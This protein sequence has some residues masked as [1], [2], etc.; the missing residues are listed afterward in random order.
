VTATIGWRIDPD[1]SLRIRR[2]GSRWWLGAGVEVSGV[3]VSG[4]EVSGIE[5]SGIEVSADADDAAPDDPTDPAGPAARRFGELAGGGYVVPRPGPTSAAATGRRRAGDWARVA[6]HL[7]RL[8]G[9]HRGE[10]VRA[11]PPE[12]LAPTDDAATLRRDL[13]RAGTGHLGVRGRVM[14]ALRRVGA[15]PG[16]PSDA[17]VAR[18]RTDLAAAQARERRAAAAWW[19]A[20]VAGDPDVV[21]PRLEQAFRVHAVPAAVAAVDPAGAD[22]AGSVVHLV[23]PVGGPA[24]VVGTR[25][26]VDDGP[27]ALRRLTEARRHGW[28]GRILDAGLLAAAAETIAVVPGVAEVRLAVIAPRHVAGPSVLGLVRLRASS[29]L[30]DAATEV[31]RDHLGDLPSPDRVVSD[32]GPTT[33]ALRPLDPTHVEVAALLARLGR[34]G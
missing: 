32:P 9:A 4:V 11:S 16:R 31:V 6:D 2:G 12:L 25:E 5:V 17:E 33:G 18:R 28:Y 7:E 8:A 23:V 20:M 13:L 24:E 1:R 29:V 14:V 27:R 3:E 15:L 21:R 34:R 26:P 19:D 22:G 30:P 10:L